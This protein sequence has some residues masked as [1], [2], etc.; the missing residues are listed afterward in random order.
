VGYAIAADVREKKR[1]SLET[2]PRMALGQESLTVRNDP[3]TL[4]APP[5]DAARRPENLPARVRADKL[6]GIQPFENDLHRCSSL[7]SLT[8]IYRLRITQWAISAVIEFVVCVATTEAEQH[9]N[10]QQEDLPRVS[11]HPKCPEISE[12]D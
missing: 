6:P 10:G 3:V 9:D 8:A 5:D 2:H 4:L 1:A 11:G 12:W 7:R